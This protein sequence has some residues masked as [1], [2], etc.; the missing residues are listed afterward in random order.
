MFQSTLTAWAKHL[1]PYPRHWPHAWPLTSSAAFAPLHS[2]PVLRTR[3]G[4]KRPRVAARGHEQERMVP[5]DVRRRGG[6]GQHNRG[7]EPR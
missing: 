1:F 3:F 2:S 7:L 5:F 6:G 4:E